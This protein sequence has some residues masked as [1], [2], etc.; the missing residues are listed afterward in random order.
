[1]GVHGVLPDDMACSWDNPFYTPTSASATVNN[2]ATQLHWDRNWYYAGSKAPLADALNVQGVY[3]ATA[4]SSA[5]P[6]F[7]CV[8][9]SHKLWRNVCEVDLNRSKQGAPILNYLPISDF[10]PGDLVVL[11]L[12]K[13][14]RIHVPPG[15]LLLWDSRTCHGNAPAISSDK[16]NTAIGRVAFPICYGPTHQRSLDVHKQALLKGISGIR[17]THHPGIML[18]HDQHGYPE[19][20]VGNGEPNTNLRDIHIPLNVA[21]SEN[22]FHAMIERACLDERGKAFLAEHVR[23]E[24]VQ[25]RCFDSY[26]HVGGLTPSDYYDKMLSLTVRDLRRLLPPHASK[27]QGFHPQESRS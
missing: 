12:L 6:S 25:K 4:T 9:G 23:L 27:T 24:N 11:G 2:N 26:W 18:A 19:G 21:V 10:A 16:W 13:P 17:T 1:M 22:E 5:T 8:P 20:F 3:Y 14:V 15:S 7:V